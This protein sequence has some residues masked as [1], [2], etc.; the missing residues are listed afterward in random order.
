MYIEKVN[1]TSSY[2]MNNSG[3][4]SCNCYHFKHHPTFKWQPLSS[5]LYTLN[6]GYHSN[7]TQSFYTQT[8][9]MLLHCLQSWNG[10]VH[11]NR[12]ALEVKVKHD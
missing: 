9:Q 2:C 12:S 8:W 1:L 3:S 11:D 7:Y 6:I 5:V 4:R 10:L